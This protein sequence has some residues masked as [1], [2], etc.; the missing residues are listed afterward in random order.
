MILSPA[1]TSFSTTTHPTSLNTARFVNVNNTNVDILTRVLRTR[2]ITI[3]NSSHTRDTGASQLRALNVAIR[4]KRQTRGITRTRAIICSDTVG[5][6][7]PRVITTRTTN[8]HVIRHDSVLTLLVGNGQTIAI[9]KTRNGAAADSV[10]SRVLIG[11]N[12]S[13]DCTVNNFV[14]NPSNAALSNKRTNGN[15]VLITRTSRSSNDFTGCRPAV[16][17]VAGY[18]TSRLSRCNSRTRCHTTFITR[19]NQTA[20]RIVVDVSSPS[21]LTILRTLPT[22]IGSRAIT[23]NAATH[24]SLPSLNNTTCI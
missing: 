2:K 21:K 11:T 19:T 15:S 10:L 20:N 18:R 5:P 4:F 7:G 22:S 24:R 3:S 23:C 12:T 16:T 1:C 8:G 6:S 17:V 13:P 14:R 9:T